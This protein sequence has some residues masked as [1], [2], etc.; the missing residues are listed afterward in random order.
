M[1]L[2][3]FIHTIFIISEQEKLAEIPPDVLS[4]MLGEEIQQKAQCEEMPQ[5]TE[6]N[7]GPDFEKNG[8]TT[9]KIQTQIIVK[10]LQK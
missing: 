7:T 3:T 10:R 4:E 5:N 6:I 8:N 1:L 9:Y 2:Q